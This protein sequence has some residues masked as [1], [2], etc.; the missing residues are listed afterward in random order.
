MD[1]RQARKSSDP[2]NLASLSTLQDWTWEHNR[3]LNLTLFTLFARGSTGVF[4]GGLKW[5]SGRWLGTW[6]SLISLASQLCNLARQPSWLLELLLGIGYLEHCLFWTHWQN[7]FWKCTNAWP[8][9]QGDVAG[10]PHLGLVEP[11]LCAMSFT[12]VIL[13]VIMPYFGHNEDMHWFW[14]IWC[15]SIIWCSW[16]GRSTKLVELVSNKHL[17]SISWMKCRYVDGKYM[18]LWPPTPPTVRV[19]LVPEQKKRIKS[20]GHKQEL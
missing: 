9:G 7:S 2:Q 1:S 17:S 8:V 13:S 10:R 3:G 4:I 19:L 14:F 5:C 20:L 11:V 16:N 6:G 15:F 18:H 12:H